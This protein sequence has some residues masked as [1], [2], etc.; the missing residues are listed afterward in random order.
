MTSPARAAPPRP[1]Q[2]ADQ[3]SGRARSSRGGLFAIATALSRAL[4]Y[5]TICTSRLLRRGSD[6]GH[7]PAADPL[8][9][10][11]VADAMSPFQPQLA[12][13]L[14]PGPASGPGPAALPRQDTRRHTPQVLFASEP[15]ARALRQLE[16]YGRDGLPVI[17]ADRQRLQGWITCQ[18]VL[19]AVAQHISAAQ[20]KLA[21]DSARPGAQ[22]WPGEPPAPLPGYPILDHRTLRDPGEPAGRVDGASGA[23][24]GRE[25][26]APA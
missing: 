20:E 8:Q 19:H 14:S 6:V 15:L 4:G 23:A 18:D 7:S 1:R 10:L 17:S 26:H 13:A 12:V 21:A 2:R 9:D 11:T 24:A 5:G 16:L 25:S 22:A 3:A